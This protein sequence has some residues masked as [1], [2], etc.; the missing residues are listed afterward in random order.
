MY[1]NQDAAMS[2]VFRS[3]QSKGNVKYLSH[4]TLL[5]TISNGVDTNKASSGEYDRRKGMA[6]EV[7]QPKNTTNISFRLRHDTS[8]LSV[9]EHAG[10]RF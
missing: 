1:G 9:Q 8:D 6:S 10:Q 3:L 7:L 5:T 4:L 2:E